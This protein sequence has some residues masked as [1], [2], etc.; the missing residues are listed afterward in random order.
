[1]VSV[2]E[3]PTEL[4]QEIVQVLLPPKRRVFMTKEER[5]TL[6]KLNRTNRRFHD[7]VRPHI[8]A[9]FEFY[10]YSFISHSFNRSDEDLIIPLSPHWMHLQRLEFWASED[11]APFVRNC[12]VLP[13]LEFHDPLSSPPDPKDPYILSKAFYELLPRF[14]NLEYFAAFTLHFTNVAI[15][16]LCLLPKLQSVTLD[17][18]MVVQGETLHPHGGAPGALS[19]LKLDFFRFGNSDRSLEEWWIR[20]LCPDTLRSLH[21]DVSGVRFTSSFINSQPSNPPC[22]PNVRN[23]RIALGSY[24]AS[25]L[26]KFP[27]VRNLAVVADGVILGGMNLDALHTKYC[28]SLETYSGP[29]AILLA[30]HIGALEQLT[31]EDCEPA[32]FLAK[33]RAVD[34][35][36]TGVKYLRIAFK[37]YLSSL[38][39]L[40]DIFSN[41]VYLRV[42]I[43]GRPRISTA[44][45]DDPRKAMAF[46]ESL[47]FS[48]PR[49]LSRLAIDWK[50]RDSEVVELPDFKKVKDDILAQRLRLKTLWINCGRSAFLWSKNPQRTAWGGP[51]FAADIIPRFEMFFRGHWSPPDSANE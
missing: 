40:T 31:I 34:A 26:A 41:V 23:L 25:P 42:A 2:D 35:K 5:Q 29:A 45:E 38:H 18:C 22:F 8:F 36:P 49:K 32:D 50:F 4:W 46:F 28:P 24:N 9:D 43:E 44:S 1:M 16:N 21:L 27:G 6:L 14:T 13:P 15:T 33:M 37:G 39:E 48:L 20:T 11:I 19:K 3:I 30:L 7:L 47:P 17:R 12:A 10:P 51:E